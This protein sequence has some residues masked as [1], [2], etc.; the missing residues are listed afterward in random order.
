LSAR[1][2]AAALADLAEERRIKEIERQQRHAERRAAEA[3]RQAAEQ[4]DRQAQARREQAAV[5]ALIDSDRRHNAFARPLSQSVP[6]PESPQSCSES[7][8]E[9]AEAPVR[10]AASGVFMLAH[11]LCIRSRFLGCAMVRYCTAGQ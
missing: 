2:K 6:V 1:E 10:L 4:A 5:R 8:T 7:D 3:V 9:E 11:L